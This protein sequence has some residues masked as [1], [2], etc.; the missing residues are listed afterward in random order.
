M[1]IAQAASTAGSQVTVSVYPPL[2]AA[3]GNT[4]NLN[5]PIVAGMEVMVLPSHRA[6]M[7][8]SGDPL[9]LRYAKTA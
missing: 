8:T 7:I 9:F 3:A 5:Q 1:A 6:G 4:Q 2:Q